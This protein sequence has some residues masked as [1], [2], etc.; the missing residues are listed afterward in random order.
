MAATAVTV[1]SR[2]SPAFRSHVFMLPSLA[3][4]A[5]LFG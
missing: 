3:G 5:C 2:S 1:D 4:E